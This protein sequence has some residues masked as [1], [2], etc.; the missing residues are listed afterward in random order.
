MRNL[1]EEIIYKA[2]VDFVLAGHVHA[3]ERL[4]PIYNGTADMDSVNTNGTIYINPKYPTY[5]VCGTGGNV[6]GYY[7]CK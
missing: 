2:K 4:Y 6:E 5:V 3:Y 1:Y 7:N